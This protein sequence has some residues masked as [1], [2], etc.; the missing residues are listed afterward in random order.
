MW[1]DFRRLGR[2]RFLGQLLASTILAGSMAGCSLT[3]SGPAHTGSI[4]DSAV[5]SASDLTQEQAVAEVQKWGAAYS[6][7]EKDRKAALNYAAALRAAG[8][9]GQAVAVMRKA[10]IYHADDREILA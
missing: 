5:V 2:A 8:Q 3:S 1:G 4:G 9:T 7:N 6:R 10:V